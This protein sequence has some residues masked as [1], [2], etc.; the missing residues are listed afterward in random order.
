MKPFDVPFALLG[1]L[2]FVA[3]VPVWMWF[4]TQHP[5]IEQLQMEARFLVQFSLPASLLFYLAS[6]FGPGGD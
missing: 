1:F 2:G 3:V 6:W 4:T 5:A